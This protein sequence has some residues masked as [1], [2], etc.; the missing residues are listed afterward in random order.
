MADVMDEIRAEARKRGDEREQKEA[1]LRQQQAKLLDLDRKPER[2]PERKP[3]AA[4]SSSSTPAPPDRSAGAAAGGAAE[5]STEADS[6][7]LIETSEITMPMCGCGMSG[8]PLGTQIFGLAGMRPPQEA[9][10]ARFYKSWFED[11]YFPDMSKK[12]QKELVGRAK[13]K[14]FFSGLSSQVK[15][16][17]MAN[18]DVRLQAEVW[19]N[20]FSQHAP[21][22]F[23]LYGFVRVAKVNLGS[24][25]HPCW[26]KF[27]GY[28]SSDGDQWML[29]PFASVEPDISAI[30]DELDGRGGMTALLSSS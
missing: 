27:W 1:M 11:D 14:G 21:P 7:S 28:H 2:K 26:T 18:T 19:F 6:T 10:F 13:T 5:S 30:L 25:A 9:S 20:Y 3:Q 15:K 17:A 23:S 29:A 24:V 8:E 12:L 16:W 4:S 22:E